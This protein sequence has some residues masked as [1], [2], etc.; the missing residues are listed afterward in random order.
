M[1]AE[2]HRAQGCPVSWKSQRAGAMLTTT[3]PPSTSGPQTGPPAPP[4]PPLQEPPGSAQTS[5]SRE[6][7]AQG[8]AREPDPGTEA[9]TARGSG[10]RSPGKP[11]AE[12]D[13][14]RG[15]EEKQET[16]ALMPLFRTQRVGRPCRKARKG[17]LDPPKGER[18]T[19]SEE[20]AEGTGLTSDHVFPSLR[21]QL[22]P[23]RC[24]NTDRAGAGL[25]LQ[26]PR[27][28][29]GNCG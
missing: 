15:S 6:D 14:P 28:T 5:S 21:S 7:R 12:L 26:H 20:A 19:P 13:R 22:S 9:D 2:R 23:T 17:A 3:P 16:V 24:T 27:R 8:N 1:C 25:T 11:G 18:K 29:P 10:A 4:R